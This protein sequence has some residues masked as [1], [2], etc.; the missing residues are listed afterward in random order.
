M[1][2]RARDT[3]PDFLFQPTAPYIVVLTTFLV[4]VIGWQ[5]YKFHRCLRTT[6]IW[7]CSRHMD[8]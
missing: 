4:V 3:L 8:E 7:E 5:I 2:R 1:T 6:S